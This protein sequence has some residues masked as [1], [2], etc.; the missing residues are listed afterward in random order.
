MRIIAIQTKTEIQTK[1]KTTKT[2]F[3]QPNQNTHTKMMIKKSMLKFR[4]SIEA[5]QMFLL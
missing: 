3:S 2:K 4:G 1:Q 5:L